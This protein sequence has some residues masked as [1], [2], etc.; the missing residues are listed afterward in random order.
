MRSMLGSSPLMPEYWRDA[1][2]HRISWGDDEDDD[3]DEDVGS[4]VRSRTYASLMIPILNLWCELS[5]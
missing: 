2:S 3:D 4:V 5:L 1:F